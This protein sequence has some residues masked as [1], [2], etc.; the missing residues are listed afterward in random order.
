MKK[1][2]DRVRQVTGKEKPSRDLGGR[3][4]TN[5]SSG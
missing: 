4:I 3:F 2:L 1:N 5:G